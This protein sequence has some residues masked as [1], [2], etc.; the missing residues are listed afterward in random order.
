MSSA[1]SLAP[2]ARWLLDSGIQEPSGGCARFYDAAT[3]KSRAISTEIS[4]YLASALVYLF[5][6]TGD[7]AYLAG[8]RK[9]AGFL[10]NAW[11]EQLR[12][13]PFEPSSRHSSF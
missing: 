13:F 1:L 8:A 11:D 9:T 10:V 5:R 12:A 7:E 2:A 4:G 6:V 3:A